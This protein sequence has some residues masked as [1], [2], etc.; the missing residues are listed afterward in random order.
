MSRLLVSGLIN[1]ETTLKVDGFPIGYTPVNYPFFGIR[2]SVSGVGYNVAKAL[3]A[4]GDEVAFLS[5]IGGD[6][7]GAMTR[8]QLAVDGIPDA[9][10]LE[11]LEHTPQSIILYDGQGKREIFVDLKNI[12]ESSYPVEDFARAVQ[13]CAMLA[14]CNI[15]FSRPFLGMARQ[16][17]LP[18]ATDV[19]V[20]GNLDDEY[21]RDFM[22]FADVL[23]MSDE[24]LPCSPQEW[25]QRVAERYHPRVIVI[26]MGREGALLHVP[27]DDI[28]RVYPA[29]VTRPVVSTIGAGDALFSAFIHAYAA[30]ASPEN[31]LQQAIIFASYKI[32]VA[33]ASDGFLT[34]G[35]LASLVHQ[36]QS[37][38][39]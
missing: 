9:N 24:W 3:T 30:G 37:G 25:A 15:N 19:H 31:A 32:G 27:Q 29:V 21:N 35:E 20:I 2:S 28:L 14:L 8:S 10:V 38:L 4:L 26:G 17:G 1:I 23:F 34:A 11:R 13:G 36:H 18:V 22:Q 6:L 5:M 33:S 39:W 7:N 12:Q 16:M